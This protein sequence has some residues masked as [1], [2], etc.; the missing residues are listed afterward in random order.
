MLALV[1]LLRPGG[2]F[3]IT[4]GGPGALGDELSVE[5]FVESGHFRKCC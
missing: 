2:D 3:E 5:D 1:A 4:G